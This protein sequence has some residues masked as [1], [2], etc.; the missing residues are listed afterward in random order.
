MSRRTDK[1]GRSK[2]SLGS[3]VAVERYL[4]NSKAWLH[5]K[6]MARAAYLELAMAYNGSNNGRIAFA[7]RVMAE[8]LGVDKAT[9][10]RA[11]GELER[12]GFLFVTQRSAYHIKR[13][14][15]FRLTAFKCDRTGDLASKL[16]M[17]WTFENKTSV[18]WMQLCGCTSA[19]VKQKRPR[20]Q[21]L[22]LHQCN[23]NAENETS[24][25]CTSAPLLYSSHWPHAPH[26][27]AKAGAANYGA[28]V[29][30]SPLNSQTP[31]ATN[32]P[33]H[34]AESFTTITGQPL[35]S[36]V[37]IEN[38]IPATLEADLPWQ[39]VSEP[40]ELK[41][42]LARLGCSIKRAGQS[43]LTIHKAA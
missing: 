22:Q 14:A 18:A 43:P 29:P 12:H 35:C 16:F 33:A 2:G 39:R 1:K 21:T 30:T 34:G 6:P 37:E 13:S 8:R 42:A 36:L 19:T 38:N 41:Y 17:Q 10:S 11:I 32:N 31:N 24:H 7:S 4:L 23:S 15:E 3:F 28:S 40:N 27:P 20:K 5:L 9:A 26:S 25:S